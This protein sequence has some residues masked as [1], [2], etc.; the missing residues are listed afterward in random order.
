MPRPPPEMNSCEE[1]C[2]DEESCSEGHL[3]LHPSEAMPTS[4]N[5]G[6][7][8]RM[9]KELENMLLVVESW[10]ITESM[11]RDPLMKEALDALEHMKCEATMLMT[12]NDDANVDNV[13]VC[14]KSIM[15]CYIDMKSV[16]T[17]IAEE[18]EEVAGTQGEEDAMCMSP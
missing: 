15:R 4:E 13:E 17:T 3:D 8:P 10:S 18:C 5:I 1:G 12:T 16:F 6:T 14:Y 2:S 11:K 7:V 9:K